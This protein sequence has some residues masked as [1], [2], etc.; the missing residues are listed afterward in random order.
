MRIQHDNDNTAARELQL[1]AENVDAYITPVLRTLSKK[2]R[3]GVFEFGRAVDYVDRYC[4]TP[5]A[6]Q[7][8]LEF[9]GM[10]DRWSD[11]FPKHVRQVAAECIVRQAVAEFRLG[12]YYN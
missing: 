5:A 4:L 11:V 12:N 6:K 8:R 1:F 3:A 7:Y 10:R 9:C 2:H